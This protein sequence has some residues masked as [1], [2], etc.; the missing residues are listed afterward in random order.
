[1]PEVELYGKPCLNPTRHPTDPK[2]HYP[3]LKVLGEGCGK[4]KHTHSPVADS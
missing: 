2:K 4:Y 3:L 1:M